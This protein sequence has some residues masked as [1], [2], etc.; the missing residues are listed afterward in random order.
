[1][2]VKAIVIGASISLYACAF[3]AVGSEKDVEKLGASLT[4]VGAEKAGNADGSIPAY[5]GGLTK[6]PADYVKGSG[7]RPDPFATEKPLYSITGANLGKYEANLTEGS[8]ALLKKYPSYRMDVY[9]THRTVAFPEYVTDN[10]RGC[11]NTAQTYNQGLSMKGCHAGFPF[12]MP[13]DGFEAMWNHLT[14]FVGRAQSYGFKSLYVDSTGRPTL[15][16]GGI[17]SA[18][19]P[20]WDNN[21]ASDIFMRVKNAYQKPTR[22]NGV[23]I[24]IHDALN[25]A[26]VG[27]KA[28]SYIPGQRRTK[29]SPAVA[30]DTPNP[31]M[32]GAATYDDTWLFFGSMERFNFKLV[33]KK[34]IFVPYNT[35][36]ASYHTNEKEFFTP[37]H[38]NPDVVRWEKHRVWV[39]EANLGEGKRHIYSK[40]VFYLDED[41]WV[42]LASDQYDIRGALYRPGF[43]FMAPSYEIP[44]PTADFHVLYDLISGMYATNFFTAEDGGV[45]QTQPLPDR[46]WSPTSLAGSGIR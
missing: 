40:R 15:T 11:A 25:A 42:A 33:G 27:R 21:S 20:Y 35:Y 22:R 28:W 38:L 39:V 12:P 10:T 30:F 7:I 44:S 43:A 26:E 29:L 13:K 46:D 9:P 4:F 45:V 6:V 8:K 31:S 23:T 19:F 34:E 16:S 41:S 2:N 1:M 3:L 36:R 24:M 17:Y 14:R 32:G 18:D 37:D 5:T